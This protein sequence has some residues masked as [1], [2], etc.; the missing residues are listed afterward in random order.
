MKLALF[1]DYR[2][3]LLKDTSV[4]DVN[5]A[6][7]GVAGSSP[8]AT[9][10]G[11]I[12]NFDAL[13]PELE[14]QLRSGKEVPLAA[15]RLRAPL[16]RP[17]KILCMGGNF[18]EFVGRRGEMWGFLKSPEA[19]LDPGGSVVLPPH[20][21]SIFH[22]EAELV[23]VIGR[24][25]SRVSSANAMD[26]VFG[27]MAGVDV[28]GRFPD[29]PRNFGKS[30]DTFAPIGPCIVTADE[31][32][33]PHTLQVRFWVD[34]QPRHDYNMS[35]IAHPVPE[36]LEWATA[37]M[38]LRPG[39]LFFLGTNHQ[40][41]GPLQDGEHAEIEIEKIGRFGFHISDPLKR[42]WPKQIDEESAKDVREGAGGPGRRARP[43]SWI[44]LTKLQ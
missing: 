3:G 26:Y 5:D 40:G 4:V 27:Y 22:H 1:D 6:V 39:D 11:V 18:Q 10:E 20:N 35:D 15:V 21:A 34:G 12:S 25:C 7:R 23:A 44:T 17:G 43:L 13:R 37:M 28:S 29:N 41:I 30:F 36:F 14:R 33:D 42:R 19:V 32:G 24:E 16:P 31:I 38:T 8:Q 9:M 2:V